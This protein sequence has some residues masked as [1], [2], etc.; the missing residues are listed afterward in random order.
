VQNKLHGQ[1][2]KAFVIAACSVVIAGCDSVAWMDLRF[3]LE[4]PICKEKVLSHI[5]L[6]EE[7]KA[8]EAEHVL[9]FPDTGIAAILRKDQSR[10][11]ANLWS[12]RNFL[13]LLREHGVDISV[14]AGID[15]LDTICGN[16]HQI[17]SVLKKK[18]S[19]TITTE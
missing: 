11:L 18:S 13:D 15:D 8:N 14:W 6:V 10:T 4:K 3:I 1:D 7:V 17:L 5:Q 19:I 16:S 12:D 9:I 2:T